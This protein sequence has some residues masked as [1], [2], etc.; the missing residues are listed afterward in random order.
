MNI[1]RIFT[2]LFKDIKE[3]YIVVLIM[4]CIPVFVVL[5]SNLNFGENKK[6]CIIGSDTSNYVEKLEKE[7]FTVYNNK[8]IDEANELLKKNEILAYINL[9]DMRV[10]TKSDDY[11]SLLQ[12]KNALTEQSDEAVN[13]ENREVSKTSFHTFLCIILLVL[14]TFLG[15]PIVFLSD[16]KDGIYNYLCMTPLKKSEYLISKL[17]FA[18]ISALFSVAFY[19]LVICKYE[20]NMAYFTIIL[21]SFAFTVTFVAGII[22]AFFNSIDKYILV[23]FPIFIIVIVLLII[24]LNEPALYDVPWLKC[25]NN[26]LI[27]NSLDIKSIVFINGI[28]IGLGVLYLIIKRIFIEVK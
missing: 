3:N 5:L 17:I 1:K 25:M 18:F 27:S 15:I 6:V 23:S 19:I 13:I 4:L 20:V 9:S 8:N 28:N 16:Y 10:I 7:D 22:S 21:A 14:L 26:L 12:I 24:G 2:I 11:K